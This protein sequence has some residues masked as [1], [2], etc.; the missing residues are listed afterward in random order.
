M[1]VLKSTYE[2]LEKKYDQL[3]NDRDYW[4]FSYNELEE[5]Y[6]KLA[7]ALSDIGVTNTNQF[8]HLVTLDSDEIKSLISLCH[9][10]RHD[11]KESS[12]RMTQKFLDIRDKR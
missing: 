7:K 3:K 8:K 1:F 6:N 10:D 11:G 12:K 2:K 4:R 5:K 9:P